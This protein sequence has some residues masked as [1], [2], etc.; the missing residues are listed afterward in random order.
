MY[1]VICSP[2]YWSR[3]KSLQQYGCFLKDSRNILIMHF[4]LLLKERTLD[5]IGHD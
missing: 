5:S 1:N 3:V 2:S 4:G